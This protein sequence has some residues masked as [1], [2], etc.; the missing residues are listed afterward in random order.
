MLREKTKRGGE[1]SFHFLFTYLPFGF[2]KLGELS[3]A[4]KFTFLFIAIFTTFPRQ[5]HRMFTLKH[6]TD[7]RVL[8]TF[9]KHPSLRKYTRGL[10]LPAPFKVTNLAKVGFFFPMS[11]PL[12]HLST[13][14]LPLSGSFSTALEGFS[15]TIH[16]D[17]LPEANATLSDA[18]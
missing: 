15:S 4:I 8:S 3:K 18:F 9:P 14:S 6:G 5:K 2:T 16:N 17:K 11:I 12:L 7:W 10:Q 1:F 13:S